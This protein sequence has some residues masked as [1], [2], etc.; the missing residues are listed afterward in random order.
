MGHVKDIHVYVYKNLLDREWRGPVQEPI[1]YRYL[2]QSLIHT[3]FKQ[4]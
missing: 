3:V 1:Q 4:M 2:Y